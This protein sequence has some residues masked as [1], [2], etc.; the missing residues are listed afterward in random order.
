MGADERHEVELI[1]QRDVVHPSQVAQLPWA[2]W[3]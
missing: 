1:T 3:T 2:L